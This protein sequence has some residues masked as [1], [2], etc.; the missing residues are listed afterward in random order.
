MN[1]Q[2][3]AHLTGTET[4]VGQKTFSLSP[5]VPDIPSGPSGAINANYI[6]NL[7]LTGTA[8]LANN[9]T[10]VGVNIFT[11]S[12]L[13]PIGVSSN[14]AVTKAQLDAVVI[15]GNNLSGFAGVSSLQGQ[16]GNVFLQGAGDVNITVCSGLIIISGG[17]TNATQFTSTYI[18]LASG[19][20]GISYIYASGYSVRPVVLANIALNGLSGAFIEDLI[21][22]PTTGGFN[23]AFNVPIPTTGYEYDI[24]IVPSTGSSGYLNLVG[25]AGARGSSPNARGVWQQGVFYN[26]LDYVYT[27]PLNISFITTSGHVS[28]LSNAPTSTGNAF[29]Q[30]L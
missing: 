27:S 3:V 5:L 29:W 15:A 21:Y 4:F 19:A 6:G 13:I 8:I 14:A 12:P 11:Q 2:G 7:G 28:T 30:I 16:S 20:T 10:F 17:T 23:V 9:Q 26:V 1:P 22:N 18:P 24:W 25:A